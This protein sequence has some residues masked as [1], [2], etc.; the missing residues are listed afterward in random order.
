MQDDNASKP[1]EF[2]RDLQLWYRAQ[3]EEN[4]SAELDDA[5]MTLAKSAVEKMED[6]H[7]VVES[8]VWRRYRWPISSAASVMLV[9]TSLLVN[10]E[11]TQEIVS[12]EIYTPAMMQMRTPL[13][14]E[15]IRHDKTGPALM[16]ISS[17]VQEQQVQTDINT[18]RTE[19]LSEDVK[20]SI[21]SLAK[22]Q[23]NNRMP[24]REA[25]VSAKQALNHLENLVKKDQWNEA[26][27]LI[28]KMRKVYPELRNKEHPEY[29][30]WKT[31]SEQV[32]ISLPNPNEP[33]VDK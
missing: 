31:L 6:N 28:F 16:Q 32:I 13:Q 9:A 18:E 29:L 17:G 27:K 33:M 24:Q 23:P 15:S 25:V 12:D 20:M 14:K 4:A 11:M 22:S 30:R 7:F 26:K 3:A 1:A 10:Q 21:G 19:P 5:I 8:S 2:D